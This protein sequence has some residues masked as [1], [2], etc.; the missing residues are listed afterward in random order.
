MFEVLKKDINIFDSLNCG[1]IF[2]F[3][4]VDESTYTVVSKDQLAYIKASIRYCQSPARFE[5]R[6]LPKR[7]G[8][9]S[10]SILSLRNTR[11]FRRTSGA[12]LRSSFAA[13]SSNS[14]RHI[15]FTHQVVQCDGLA[16]CPEPFLGQIDVLH[17]LQM[18]LQS[19]TDVEG[20]RP[21]GLSR[22]NVQTFFHF[23][24]QTHSDHHVTS[25]FV[26]RGCYTCIT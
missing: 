24:R 5:I 23:L 17:F 3:K 8:S 25:G 6:A 18:L 19:L 20:F 26:L 11:I 7:R 12:S 4:E 2:R 15:E 14:T 13:R 21:P 1:Q 9:S 22:E 16:E 10:V